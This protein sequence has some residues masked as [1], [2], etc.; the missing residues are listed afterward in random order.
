M[1]E[2]QELDDTVDHAIAQRHK[3]IDT[4][5]LQ[6]VYQLC[7]QQRKRHALASPDTIV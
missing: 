2:V 3:G 7:Y 6:S 5:G 1:G 4:S